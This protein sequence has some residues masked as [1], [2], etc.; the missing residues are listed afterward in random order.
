MKV[1]NN[2]LTAEPL[3][4]FVGERTVSE[5]T[6]IALSTLRNARSLRRGLPHYKLDGSRQGA[7]KYR[8]SDVLEWMESKRIES[9][10]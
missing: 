5:I 1:K 2:P 3:P 9:E 7:V 10:R 4:K 8:L 6:G